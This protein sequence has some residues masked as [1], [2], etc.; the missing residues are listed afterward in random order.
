M[1]EKSNN[2]PGVVRVAG[3]VLG[4]GSL[5]MLTSLLGVWCGLSL[6]RWHMAGPDD[7]LWVFSDSNPFLGLPPTVFCILTSVVAWIVPLRFESGWLYLV[8][9]VVDTLLWT[10]VTVGFNDFLFGIGWL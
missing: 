10:A 2:P 6:Y 5:V 1:S 4:W 9:A 3:R 7:I 8:A